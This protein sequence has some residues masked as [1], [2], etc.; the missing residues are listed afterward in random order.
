MVAVPFSQEVGQ[1]VARLKY[2]DI[3]R[4]RL[5]SSEV[6]EY[7]L[8]DIARLKRHQIEVLSSLSPSLA[9]VL[10]SERASERYVLIGEAI[11]PCPGDCSNLTATA[12]LGY[13]YTHKN[14]YR[15]TYPYRISDDNT[16]PHTLAGFHSA[17]GCVSGHHRNPDG[18]QPGC[19]SAADD[20]LL[21]PRGADRLTRR[22]FHG[23]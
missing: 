11:Q 9:I 16:H 1:A 14:P 7:R 23:V 13:S 6:V 3:L 22:A 18:D 8:V 21:Q 17:R 15:N 19:W 20:H 4:L 10:H 12:L 5:G 2:G